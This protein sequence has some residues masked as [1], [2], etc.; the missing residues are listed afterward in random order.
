MD[1]LQKVIY[2][3]NLFKSLEGEQ[4]AN[5][6]LKGINFSEEVAIQIKESS[7]ARPLTIQNAIVFSNVKPLNVDMG[8]ISIEM[9]KEI[10]QK[11]YYIAPLCFAME[12]LIVKALV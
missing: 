9:S 6:Y 7:R 2:H 5:E 11:S 3:Y 8:N 10:L 1:Y 12:H 4:K